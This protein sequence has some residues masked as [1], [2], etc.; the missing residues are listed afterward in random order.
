M[1]TFDCSPSDQSAILAQCAEAHNV[2]DT[3]ADPPPALICKFY[4]TSTPEQ[5]HFG[6]R[7]DPKRKSAI[8][9]TLVFQ[10]GDMAEVVAIVR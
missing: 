7:F 6:F 10:C 3:M 4:N 9:D 2:L 1:T 8:G 5:Y